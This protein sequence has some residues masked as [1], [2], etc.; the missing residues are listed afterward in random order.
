MP[1]GQ[2]PVPFFERF[3]ACLPEVLDDSQCWLWQGLRNPKGYGR[4][5]VGGGHCRTV[6][7]H[8]A[9]WEM[10]HAA[11]IPQGMV[12]MHA[13]DTPACVNPCHLRLGT[14]LQNQQDK[15][16]KGRSLLGTTNPRA[17]LTPEQVV[18][19]RDACDR[20]RATHRQLAHQYGVSKTAITKIAARENWAY[21]P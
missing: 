12:I 17:K 21:L 6:Y 1:R 10:H 7:A 5:Y 16:L 20:R 15:A 19:I 13:C 18:L 8:R 9:A 3:E 11:P 2:V 14:Q 4:I